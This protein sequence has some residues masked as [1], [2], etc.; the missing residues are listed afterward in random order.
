VG[1]PKI[2]FCDGHLLIGP[3]PKKEKE[4]KALDNPKIDTFYSIL[5][6]GLFIQV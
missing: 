3:A 2:Q 4:K 6:L 5:L 1:T